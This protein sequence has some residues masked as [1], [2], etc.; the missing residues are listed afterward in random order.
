[1]T[2]GGEVDG[3]LYSQGPY[4]ETRRGW[5]FHSPLTFTWIL[6]CSRVQQEEAMFNRRKQCL[7]CFWCHLQY[8]LSLF[9]M[10]SFPFSER[11][12]GQ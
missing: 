10:R 6:V 1:M 9:I 11:N 5:Y 3:T 8:L 7:T 4:H 2:E 12:F